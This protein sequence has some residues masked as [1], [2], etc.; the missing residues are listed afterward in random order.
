[1]KTATSDLVDFSTESFLPIHDVFAKTK[2][3]CSNLR[4]VFVN[5]ISGHAMTK[6]AKKPAKK[7]RPQL[8]SLES[9]TLFAIDIVSLAP[10]ADASAVDP[11]ANLEIVFA[12]DVELG[13]GTGNITI[14]NADDGS[15][16]EIISASSDQVTI[17]GA[18]VSIDPSADL[19]ANVNFAVSVD[20]SAF[21]GASG[22]SQVASLLT[23][24]F[25]SLPLMDSPLAEDDVIIDVNDYAISMKGVLDVQVA[26][27]YTFGVNSDDGQSLAIDVAQDGFDIF[28]D[29][30]IFDNN[31]HG[32]QDRLH[33]CGIDVAV[34]S[35]PGDSLEEAITLEVGEYEFEYRYYERGGGSSGEFYYAPGFHEAFDANVFAIVGDPAQGIGVTAAGIEVTTYK[36]EGIQVG[37]LETVDDLVAGFD[38]AEGFPVSE[39]YEFA[40]VH[41]SGGR[42]RFLVDN[43]LPG[44]P[45]PQEGDDLDWTPTPPQGWVQDNSEMPTLPGPDGEVGTDDD[46]RSVD[47]YF[48][49]NFLDKFWW[50]NQQGNQSRTDFTKGEGTLAVVDPDA[51]DD[52]GLGIGN[53]APPESS[54]FDAEL[55][56]PND[57][58]DGHRGEYR[59]R[60]V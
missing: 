33:V 1:M 20:A 12:E 49:W 54:L 41:N 28:E 9:K 47:E 37:S 22:G 57:L 42:G 52:F 29:E 10:A 16:I 8:E 40:D 46:E 48:G 5:F 39:T 24:D 56:S 23:E 34:Q 32:T 36:A 58:F 26:G 11:S 3:E 4:R 2:R 14:T 17:D 45:P 27:E 21:L 35:C 13:P 25:E 31:N 18:T 6:R 19:P 53:G 55:E 7:L 15:V 60:E 43:P 44:F 38:L 59:R 50:V 30:I 51:F